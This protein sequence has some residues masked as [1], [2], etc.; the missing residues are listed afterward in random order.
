MLESFNRL[1]VKN[2]VRAHYYFLTAYK[3]TV[4]KD[5]KPIKPLGFPELSAAKFHK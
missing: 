3:T 1:L 5:E 2:K 4:V